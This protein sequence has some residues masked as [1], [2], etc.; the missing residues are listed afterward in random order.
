MTPAQERETT[1]VAAAALGKSAFV[2]GRLISECPFAAQVLRR[3]WM[4]GW[5]DGFQSALVEVMGLEN[6][7]K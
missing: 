4:A 5:R 7:L 2:K 3:E 1:L 6:I